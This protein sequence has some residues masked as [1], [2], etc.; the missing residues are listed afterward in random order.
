[1]RA[2]NL[3]KKIVLSAIVVVSIIACKQNND[4]KSKPLDEKENQNTESEKPLAKANQSEFINIEDLKQL[5]PIDI[6]DAKNNNVYK[7]YGIE[8]SGNCYNC[9]LTKIT[10]TAK[11]IKLTNVC[12][13]KLNLTFEITKITNSA[14]SIEI[15]TKQNKW[16]FTKIDNAPV[17]G[18]EINGNSIKVENFRFSKFYTQ[19]NILG[20]FE[21]HDCGDFRDCKL[22]CVK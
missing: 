4:N 16:I 13:K 11:L 17:Y 10:I 2:N 14:N 7:K 8:S 19:E 21:Q 12:D 5:A 22:N 18:V 6:L 15:L 3:I 9:D 1:M 20:K